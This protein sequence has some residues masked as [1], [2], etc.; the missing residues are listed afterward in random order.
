MPDP[1]NAPTLLAFGSP[2]LDAFQLARRQGLTQA[3]TVAEWLAELTVNIG[4]TVAAQAAEALA[5]ANGAAAAVAVATSA[6]ATAQTAAD[7]ARVSAGPSIFEFGAVG[8]GVADDRPAFVA[9]NAAGRSVKV[10]RPGTRF[11]LPTPLRLTTT[12]P[13][14]SNNASWGVLT[15]N[16]QLEWGYGNGFRDEGFVPIW[17]FPGRAFFGAESM[18]SGNRLG[19]N[20]YGNSPIARAIASYIIKNAAVGATHDSPN[21]RIGIAAGSWIQPGQAGASAIAIAGIAR[22]DG[23]S[24]GS[25]GGYF[26]MV[27]ASPVAGLATTGAEIQVG[28]HTPFM[29]VTSAYAMGGSVV[30]GLQIAVEAQDHYTLGDADTLYG[31][32]LN[33]AGAAID[34]SGGGTVETWKQWVSGIVFR[35]GALRRDGSENA[36]A[37][38]LA[39]RH[40]IRWEVAAGVTGAIIGSHVTN[41][42]GR[43]QRLILVNGGI[44]HRNQSG[45]PI[46]T[47]AAADA[48][49]NGLRLQGSATVLG[50]G[51][52]VFIRSQGTAPDIDIAIRPKGLGFVDLQRVKLTGLPTSITG[53][54]PGTLW[55]DGGTLK[56]SP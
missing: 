6:A 36:D 3:E 32:G 17:R 34:V 38:I 25:R 12:V 52:P 45:A 35:D 54:A 7:Q 22:H 13:E 30:N 20:G 24:G 27:M 40:Q 4:G 31:P 11:R 41:A 15:D 21:G 10:T 50:V 37:M 44:D 29:P 56:V 39:R 55:N 42:A 51:G 23:I 8:D 5:T 26:E 16:G 18:H 49:N 33:P 1:L 19:A 28:N 53:L 47:L 14:L 9:A 46:H 43:D 2:S 48:D